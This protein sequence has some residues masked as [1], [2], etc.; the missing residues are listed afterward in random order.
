MYN[1]KK[2]ELREME[3]RLNDFLHVDKWAFLPQKSN[4][5]YAHG[6]RAGS[7]TSFANASKKIMLSSPF[8]SQ[9]LIKIWRSVHNKYRTI[10]IFF[11]CQTLL[12]KLT[13][14]SG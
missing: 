14:I 5:G 9:I 3:L 2:I 8:W 13:E 7:A 11:S 4:E 1:G 6:R 10:Y 12:H